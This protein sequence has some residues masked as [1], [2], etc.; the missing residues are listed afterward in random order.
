M[1]PNPALT[2]LAISL[3]LALFVVARFFGKVPALV[4]GSLA[5]AGV[6]GFAFSAL[7]LS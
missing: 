4:L 7:A 3:V 6:A 5:L 1:L 2:L